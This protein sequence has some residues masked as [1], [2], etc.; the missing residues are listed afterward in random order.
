MAASPLLGA[1]A[2]GEWL[3]RKL[4]GAKLGDNSGCDEPW[5]GLPDDEASGWTPRSL[6]EDMAD[7]LDGRNDRESRLAQAQ[8][9]VDRADRV[10]ADSRSPKALPDKGGSDA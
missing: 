2:G 7:H 3:Y 6:Q 10:L 8:A 4:G 9:L 1:L 5:D